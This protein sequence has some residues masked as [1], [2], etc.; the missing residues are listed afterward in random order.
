MQINELQNK[1]IGEIQAL[2]QSAGIKSV[3]KYKK[4]ELIE[5]IVETLKKGK[6]VNTDIDDM[7]EIDNPQ[8]ASLTAPLPKEPFSRS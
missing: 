2:A 1:K 8:S 6:S 4:A 3:T 7:I 5:L